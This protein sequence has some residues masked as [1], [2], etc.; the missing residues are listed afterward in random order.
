MLKKVLLPLFAAS[1]VLA[2]AEETSPYQVLRYNSGARAAALAGSTTAMPNDASMI[3]YNPAVIPT[4]Q[5]KPLSATFFKHIADI[6]SGNVAYIKK[7]ENIG[8]FS[9]SLIYTNYGTFDRADKLG[10]KKGTFSANDVVFSV[11]YGGILDSNL[12]YGAVGKFVYSGL[13]DASSTAMAFDFGL[14]YTM[15]KSN[16]N[17]GL[18]ILNAGFQLS[19]YYDYK[20]SLP[21]DVR[22]GINHRLKGLPLLANFSFHHLADSE[23]NFGD[24]F[25]NFSL[26]GEIYLG[27]KIMA[28]IGYDNMTRRKT[29]PPNDREMAGLS[30]G[31]GLKL[32]DFNLDYAISKIGL[33]ASLHRI[34]VNLNI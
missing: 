12:Y 5:D 21:L 18:S 28:R 25:L 26:G 15:P 32:K 6:N 16:T 4:V 14:L 13:E 31:V 1:V 23:N 10:V 30:A 11:G 9:A 20:E 22:L 29:A 2:S 8:T 24:K 19:K 33:S 34:S 17:I 7:F 27:D 3:F